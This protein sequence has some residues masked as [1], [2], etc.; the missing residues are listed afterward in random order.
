[1]QY[2]LPTVEK[3]AGRNFL[4][5]GFDAAQINKIKKLE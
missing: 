1:M 2:M 3:D 5:L 4:I